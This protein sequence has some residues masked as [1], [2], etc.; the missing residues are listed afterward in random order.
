MPSSAR[1][2]AS[3][4]LVAVLPLVV[5]ALLAACQVAIAGHASWAAAGAARAAARASAVGGDAQLAARRALP[6]HLDR[7]ARVRVRAA[8]QV[9]VRLVVPSLLRALDLGTIR[10]TAHFEGQGP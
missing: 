7:G 10:S 8:G 1:G 3:V 4:E 2:Q 5:A 6:S 9:E